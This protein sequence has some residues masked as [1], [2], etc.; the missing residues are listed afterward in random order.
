MLRKQGRI[1]VRE[2]EEAKG[3][4]VYYSEINLLSNKSKVFIDFA[5]S[6]RNTYPDADLISSNF[7]EQPLKQIKVYND[8]SADFIRVGFNGGSNGPVYIKIKFNESLTI[9]FV[10]TEELVLDMVL[11]ANTTNTTVRIIGLG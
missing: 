8:G 4:V 2:D 9:P 1:R 11:Q 6:G 10:D 5:D 3:F 7:T